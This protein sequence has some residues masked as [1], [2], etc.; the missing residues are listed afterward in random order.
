MKLRGGLPNFLDTKHAILQYS[1]IWE[2]MM[3]YVTEM[4]ATK[5]LEFGTREGFSTRIFAEALKE[6]K[7]EIWSIDVEK[8]MFPDELAKYDNI[9]V[10]TQEIKTLKWSERVDI[11]YIDD[12]HKKEHLYWELC[13]FSHLAKVVMCHDVCQAV[14]EGG[15]LLEPVLKFA[16]DRKLIVQVFPLNCCGLSVVEMK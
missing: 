13:N 5:V 1:G 14:D 4:K 10:L 3:G 8:P 11:L 6:T 16:Y 15:L 9:H 12:L 7:G 2:V